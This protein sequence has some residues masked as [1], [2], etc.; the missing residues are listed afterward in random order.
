MVRTL[1]SAPCNLDGKKGTFAMGKIWFLL[2]WFWALGVL[3]ALGFA[4]GFYVGG[5]CGD[6][7][8]VAAHIFTVSLAVVLMRKF[9]LAFRAANSN[10][11]NRLYDSAAVE[12][13]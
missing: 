8:L 6:N 7:W 3:S 9:G 5:Y 2:K 1:L 12:A 4:E 11:D 10:A 13:L